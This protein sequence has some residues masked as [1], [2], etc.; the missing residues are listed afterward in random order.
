MLFLPTTSV[1]MSRTEVSTV[2]IHLLTYT[3]T[4]FVCSYAVTHLRL[5]PNTTVFMSRTEPHFHAPY[6]PTPGLKYLMCQPLIF[7][8]AHYGLDSSYPMLLRGGGTLLFWSTALDTYLHQENQKNF[9]IIL[10]NT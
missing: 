5:V 8:K 4:Y 3:C 9:G 10:D 2:P 1:F 7:Q 6:I